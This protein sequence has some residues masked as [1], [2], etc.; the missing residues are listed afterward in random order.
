MRSTTG[1]GIGPQRLRHLVLDLVLLEQVLFEFTPAL[2]E[3]ALSKP[4]TQL[5]DQRLLW[6]IAGRK[7]AD[8]LDD[9]DAKLGLDRL[10]NLAGLELKRRGA[11]L[12]DHA[13]L[14]EDAEIAALIR[15]GADRVLLGEGC[16]VSV[17]GGG[18]PIDVLGLGHRLL[19]PLRFVGLARLVRG[20]V[21]VA[22]L[23]THGDQDMSGVHSVLVGVVVG[24]DLLVLLVDL[25]VTDAELAVDL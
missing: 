17:G 10:G 18:E 19:F 5:I 24:L 2:V 4:L 8:A 3:L 25:L 21:R 23:W 1:A 20:V 9:M 15:A 22:G 6:Q 7:L 13:V 16:E 12:L 11:E 14:C